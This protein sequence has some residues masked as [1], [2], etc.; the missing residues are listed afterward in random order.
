MDLF[1]QSHGKFP[2]YRGPAL[3]FE[4]A[5]ASRSKQQTFYLITQYTNPTELGQIKVGLASTN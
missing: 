5:G 2:G 3:L 4:R 1:L